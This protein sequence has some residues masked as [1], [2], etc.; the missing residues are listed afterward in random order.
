VAFI[1]LNDEDRLYLYRTSWRER[2]G[3]RVKLLWMQ[4]SA[5]LEGIDLALFLEDVRRVSGHCRDNRLLGML[6]EYERNAA[7]NTGVDDKRRL[8][9]SVYRCY[10]GYVNYNGRVLGERV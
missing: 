10:I 4:S 7:S 5:A 2:C 6:S 8:L 1:P 9:E 3:F